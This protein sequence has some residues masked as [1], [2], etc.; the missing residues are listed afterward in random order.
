MSS[1]YNTKRVV[2]DHNL[3]FMRNKLKETNWNEIL[4]TQD[5][6]Y[7]YDTFATKLK[8]IYNSVFCPGFQKGR[9][10]SE[11]GTFSAVNGPSKGHL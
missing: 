2:N 1:I 3:H 8:N 7:M 4:A 6:N 10:P 5:V 11:K 9:V